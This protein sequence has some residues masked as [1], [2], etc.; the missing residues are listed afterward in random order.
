VTLCITFVGQVITPFPGPRFTAIVPIMDLANLIIEQAK[1]NGGTITVAEVQAL[2]A[3]R[4][5]VARKVQ[6][7]WLERRGNGVL[8]LPGG[9]P[10]WHATLAAACH[11]LGG[12]VSH[13]SAAELHGMTGLRRGLLI[14]SVPVRRSNRHDG[15]D[16]R[17][18]TDLSPDQVTTRDGLPVTVV[19]R[20]VID[21]ASQLGVRRLSRLIDSSVAQG[22]VTYDAIVDLFGRLGR[23]GKPGTQRM[24]MVMEARG[25]GLDI[26][27][28]ELEHRLLGLIDRAGLPAPTTEFKAPWLAPANGRVDLAYESRCLVIEADSRRWHMLADAFLIDRER[29]NLAQLAGWRVLRFTWWDI[30]NRPQYVVSTIRKGLSA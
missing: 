16:V 18:K 1:Q 24:R 11:R 19:A 10:E 4:Q 3:T 14:V 9:N 30:E 5:W 7:G 17:Q 13:E 8:G 12:V 28:T 20:V 25:A 26:D 27:P 22:L 15:V 6:Q 29:D 23:R 21:L 2:G